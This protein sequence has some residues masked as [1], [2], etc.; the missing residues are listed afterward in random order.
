LEDNP[1]ARVFQSLG[2]VANLDEYQIELNIDIG[3]DQR[4][5]N[6]PT[7]SQVA[8]IWEEGSDTTKQFQT[9]IMVCGTSREPQY[10][11][12]Y[13]GCY[14][15]VSYPLFFP[16]GEVGWKKKIFYA[17]QGDPIQGM[18]VSLCFYSLY[19]LFFF[20]LVRKHYL[21]FQ[22]REMTMFAMNKL[23]CKGMKVSFRLHISMIFSCL[24]NIIYANSLFPLG[25]LD[26]DAM[27]D[28]VD[29]LGED[30]VMEESCKLFSFFDT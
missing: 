7:V 8:A 2:N 19:P 28:I 3:V 9:S 23:R 21:M 6:A 26:G 14:D 25:M 24:W 17:D 16:H 20:Q 4:R 5:Y 1:Y 30:K 10:I 15:P 18:C 22:L 27:E 11:K 29:E 13:H 12:A